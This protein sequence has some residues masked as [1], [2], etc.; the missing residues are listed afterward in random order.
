ML[1]KSPFQVSLPAST[2]PEM[3]QRCI[4][5]YLTMYDCYSTLSKSL[6]H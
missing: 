4:P 6:F 3:T 2:I 1:G 5:K